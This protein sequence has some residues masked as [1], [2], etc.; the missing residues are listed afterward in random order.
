MSI[1]DATG[2]GESETGTVGT[3]RP[4]DPDDSP[5]LGS[6]SPSSGG[7]GIASTCCS[8]MTGTLSLTS[9]H[10]SWHFQARSESC[11]ESDL[12]LQGTAF[13]QATKGNLFGAVL[14]GFPKTTLED[15][16]LTQRNH[17]C[18]KYYLGDWF[19]CNCG[20][21]HELVTLLSTNPAHIVI[22]TLSIP[23]WW[24]FWQS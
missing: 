2:F 7:A 15:I 23:A 4:L 10:K 1:G 21:I 14:L 19:L 5:P 18:P 17:S 13:E 3:V 8:M 11:L 22:P 16:F 24:S 9:Q 20:Q 6:L 12:L